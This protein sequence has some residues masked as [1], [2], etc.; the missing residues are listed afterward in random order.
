MK[1]TA[2]EV[3][4]IRN[5]YGFSRKQ[6]AYFLNVSDNYIYLV[7]TGREPL[8]TSLEAKILD[9]YIVDEF[10]LIAIKDVGAQ[11]R[12]KQVGDKDAE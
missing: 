5:V 10:M 6:F 3:K 1:L 7:E 12:S 9:K 2:N 11:V 4:L 8:S